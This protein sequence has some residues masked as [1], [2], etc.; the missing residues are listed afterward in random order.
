M[1]HQQKDRRRSCNRNKRKETCQSDVCSQW[2]I[3]NP[4]FETTNVNWAATERH[5]G[6]LEYHSA[7]L[8]V[9][10]PNVNMLYKSVL[11]LV[12]IE[13]NSTYYESRNAVLASEVHGRLRHFRYWM[14][15][16]LLYSFDVVKT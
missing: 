15:I 5:S 14:Y 9:F 1:S 8:R 13:A 2:G 12:G 6:N 10:S 4:S 16:E 3:K 11:V 7:T